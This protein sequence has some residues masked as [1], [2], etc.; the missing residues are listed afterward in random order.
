MTTMEAF[1]TTVLTE[2]RICSDFKFN[3]IGNTL[4]LS[5]IRN[6]YFESDGAKDKQLE[7]AITSA[8]FIIFFNYDFSSDAESSSSITLTTALLNPR[9]MK[10]VFDDDEEV[11]K[12]F[13]QKFKI[14]MVDFI[15]HPYQI[16]FHTNL[17]CSEVE[18]ISY[19]ICR[20]RATKNQVFD[21]YKPPTAFLLFE[22]K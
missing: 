9:K 14:P 15:P 7:D 4:I 5:S 12:R 19:E 21:T 16:Y 2:A 11:W 3:A 8:E 20:F 6:S 13:S 1:K 22:V 10:L 17:A 18:L